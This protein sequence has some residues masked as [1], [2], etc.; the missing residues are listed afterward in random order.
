MS[1]K[2][3][4]VLLI[5]SV[6][7]LVL[8]AAALIVSLR[9]APAAQPEGDIQYVMYLGTNGKDSNRPVFPPEEARA[10]AEKIL[11]QHFGGYTIQEAHGGWI[12]GSEVYQE[13][14]LVIY[15]SETDRDQVHA[16]AKDLIDVFDQSSV[17]IQANRTTTEFYAG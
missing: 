10:Q 13:Y 11:I 4:T 14:T 9:P 12:D 6:A 8:A 17:L 16:A 15:L 2:L 1:K 7:A 3:G 5:L